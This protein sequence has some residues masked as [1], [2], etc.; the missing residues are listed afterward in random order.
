M[1]IRSIELEGTTDGSG[2]VTVNS[3]LRISGY[4][5]RVDWVDGDL[6]DGNDAVISVQGTPSGVAQTLMT[7]TNANADAVYYPRTLMQGETGA[8]LTGSAGGDRTRYLVI[9]VP[10]LVVSSG[11]ATKTGG[12]IL[13]Y[14]PV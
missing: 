14:E 12:C 5:E 7:L 10:R 8:D 4:L 2:D 11:G 1:S 3:T 13:Y 9:G 6:A